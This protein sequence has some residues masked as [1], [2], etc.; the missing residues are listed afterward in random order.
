[1]EQNFSA[2]SNEISPVPAPKGDYGKFAAR[3][4]VGI[5]EKIA[6][7]HEPIVNDAPLSFEKMDV[8]YG[9]V[10]YETI[11]TDDQKDFEDNA[12]LVISTIRDRAIVYVDQVRVPI[13]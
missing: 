13:Y 8:D 6:Q 10:M 1:M 12:D 7:R 5:F 11:F 3:P 9:F 4:L 2:A